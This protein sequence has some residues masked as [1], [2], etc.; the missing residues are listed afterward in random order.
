MRKPL[1]R[2]TVTAMA[3][4]FT[5]DV[6][7]SVSDSALDTVMPYIESDLQ[8]ADAIFSLYQP[9]SQLSR[10]GRGEASIGEC[11]PAVAEVLDL[12]EK[13]REE[14]S[15]AFDARRPD[16][17][18]DPTG[19]VKT[20]AMER[21]RWRFQLLGA[22]AWLW[23]CAGDVTAQG[24]PDAV[25]PWRVGIADP[26]AGGATVDAVELGAVEAIATSGTAHSGE[27]I[28]DPRKGRA[29]TH[30]AQASVAGSDLVQ[31]DAWATAIM[32]GGRKVAL[33]AQ[34]EGLHVLT[35]AVREGKVFAERSPGW[36]RMQNAGR[37]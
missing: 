33:A 3:M 37:E 10:L 7:E 1:K 32:A 23:G 15:G 17:V 13:Y 29:D 20:W 4:D 6:P 24:R 35:C 19:I 14:T 8:W 16:G 21:V 26:R 36:P 27:H 31:C 25:G 2:R 34:A 22:S 30:F 28:W 12:C 9:D 5:L 11:V 18:I